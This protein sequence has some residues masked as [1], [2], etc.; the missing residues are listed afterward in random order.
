M[1]GPMGGQRATTLAGEKG[2]KQGGNK[3]GMF[4][5]WEWQQHRKLS[6]F[7]NPTMRQCDLN[8]YKKRRVQSIMQS[9]SL[10]SDMRA[11]EILVQHVGQQ[12]AGHTQQFVIDEVAPSP[13]LRG[14]H[15]CKYCRHSGTT[16]GEQYFLLYHYTCGTCDKTICPALSVCSHCYEI[17]FPTFD[18]ATCRTELEI[19]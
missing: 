11:D 8:P 16:H 13:A 18:C 7:I 3:Q 2:G 9:V 4:L 14:V 10:I 1:N 6:H 15:K 17:F 19:N 12:D 5:F